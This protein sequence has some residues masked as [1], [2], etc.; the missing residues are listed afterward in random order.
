[1]MPR[2]LISLT[3]AGAEKL[4]AMLGGRIE[5]VRSPGGL[6]DAEERDCAIIA[7]LD[8]VTEEEA[9]PIRGRVASRGPL[10]HVKGPG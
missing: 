5:I 8:A 4:E 7:G 6:R 1:M 3:D 2:Y 10:Y 9:A